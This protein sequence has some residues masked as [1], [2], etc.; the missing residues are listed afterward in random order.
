FAETLGCTPEQV[1]GLKDAGFD[2]LFNSAKW[3]DFRSPWL[4]QQYDLYR[5]VAPTIAFPESH[6]TERL[7]IELG[8]PPPAELARQ[9]R[10]RYLF[11]AC[12]SSG[13]MIPMGFE[14][15]ARTRLDVVASRP[16]D[17]QWESAQPR[18][19]LTGF[20]GAVNRMRAACPALNREGCQRK[21]TAPHSPAVGL[22]R[23]SGGDLPSSEDAAIILVNPDPARAWGVEPGPLLGQVGG[24]ISDFE[25]VTP[26]APPVPL[27]P[28]HPLTLE[29]LQL[30]VFRG[31]ARALQPARVTAKAAQQASEKRLTALAANRVVIER[32]T[33][34]LDG[35]RHAIKRVVGDVVKVEADVFCDGHDKI[36]AA[37][38]YRAQDEPGWRE[39]P[40][41][42][43]DNDR[44]GGQFPVT[45]NARYLYTIEGWRDLFASWRDE[46]MKKHD[47]GLD[48]ALELIEG[49]ELIESAQ[50]QA[51]G[52]GQKS[53]KTLLGELATLQEDQGRL[54]QV[55]LGEDVRALMRRAGV[56][57]NASRYKTELEVM[58]DRPAAK[59]AAWY[60]MFPRSQSGDPNRHGTFDDVIRRLPY[61]QGMG[62]DVLYFTPI[63]PIGK[64]NRKGRNNTLT[65][66]PD[67]PGSPYAIGSEDGGHDA[68]HPELGTFE[69]FHRLVEAAHAHGLEIAL[70]FAINC[71]PD[72]PWIKQHP[73]WF[74]WRPDGTIK[75]A[76]NPPKKY[77]D[78][79][80]VHFYRGARSTTA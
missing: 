3:W 19:D 36:A 18:I 42:F 58:V 71:S 24:R 6:D 47:A 17:W 68:L 30:R 40:L 46:V 56:R 75:Y 2:Y 33:P 4:L 69:D 70:D 49:R 21:I 60:E 44:W 5:Q 77:E 79:V 31:K 43:I 16:G 61:V 41:A 66:A 59:F 1:L 12:F 34:E 26:E 55:M 23:L 14:Y 9:S 65:P 13:V 57:T 28:G 22:L 39:A 53:L 64:K 15:G 38:K 11:A 78:I 52:E 74:D 7:A 27:V 72:H 29:P 48:V 45:R 62:F 25:D 37:I 20:I 10:M 32:V 73:E 35:G 54:L 80:N 51:K 67:D 8:D 63:H 50:A 76:E